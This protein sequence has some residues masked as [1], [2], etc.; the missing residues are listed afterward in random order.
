MTSW[1]RLH[2]NDPHTSLSVANTL[3]KE[4][5]TLLSLDPQAAI[6]LVREDSGSVFYF[7]PAMGDIARSHSAI[8]CERPLGLKPSDLFIGNAL[9]LLRPS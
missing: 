1:Y 2:I 9:A 4:A 3:S 5:A 6:F 7:T 8:A